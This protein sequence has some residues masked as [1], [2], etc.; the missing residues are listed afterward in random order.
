MCSSVNPAQNLP[1][2]AAFL[3][4][5]VHYHPR[6]IHCPKK[7]R[8]M[9]AEK[10]VWN[11]LNIETRTG[12]L[13]PML[14]TP[15]TLCRGQ[16]PRLPKVA[17]V[18]VSFSHSNASYKK[19]TLPTENSECVYTTSTIS[20]MI[21]AMLSGVPAVSFPSIRTWMIALKIEPIMAVIEQMDNGAGNLFRAA[22]YNSIRDSGKNQG[23]QHLT[24]L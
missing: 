1:K 5:K 8:E 11:G 19:I 15:G 7:I 14:S 3:L 21:Q 20:P 24:N 2:A 6:P 13:R 4:Y 12:P 23:H 22:A 17:K 9:K 10:T 16:S 18:V